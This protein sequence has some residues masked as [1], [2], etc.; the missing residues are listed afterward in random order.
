MIGS[1]PLVNAPAKALASG[2]R[3]RRRIAPLPPCPGARS[4]RRSGRQGRASHQIAAKRAPEKT[5]IFVRSNV[6]VGAARSTIHA[7]AFSNAATA[8][9]SPARID[10]NGPPASFRRHQRPHFGS[11]THGGARGVGGELAARQVAR[12][13][14]G[15]ALVDG[16]DPA[17]PVI[18][19]RARL[20][21]IPGAAMDLEPKD[22]TSART[23]PQ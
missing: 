8:L 5:Q 19:C 17:I 12:L 4:R 1:L 9:A 14:A 3:R 10:A 22:V 16:D 7:V 21:D 23:S 20:L 18:L 15:R 11:E 6:G 13:N 2:N